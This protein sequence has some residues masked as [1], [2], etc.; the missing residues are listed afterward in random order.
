MFDKLQLCLC[1]VY[2]YFLL[3]MIC[4]MDNDVYGYVNN[5]VYYSYFDIV[6]NE[7]LICVGVFDVEYGQM[8][9]L[10]VEMQCNYFVLFVFL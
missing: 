2:C 3:I 6:V 1:D 5:V 9:G 10:V 4:W 8:I 7:Y